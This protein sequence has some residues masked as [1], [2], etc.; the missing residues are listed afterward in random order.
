LVEIACH[1][2]DPEVDSTSLLYRKSNAEL[3]CDDLLQSSINCARG[4]ALEAIAAF[5]WEQPES[6]K[7]FEVTLEHSAKD[8]N[9]A[10]LFSVLHCSV[11]WY[12]IDKTF[13]KTLFDKL[14]TR[15]LRVLGVRQAWDLMRL[16]YE[17]NP[18][19][20]AERLQ[21][22]VQSPIDDL[23]N[24]AAQMVAKLVIMGYW[25]FKNLASLSLTAQQR[26]AVCHQ[27]IIYYGFDE[28]HIYCE[29]IIR[30]LTD[31]N[32]ELPSIRLLFHH[33]YLQIP[34]DQEFLIELLGKRYGNTIV[35][36]VLHYL[37]ETKIDVKNYGEILFAA[38][39]SLLSYREH[40]LKYYVN[41]LIFCVA[42]LFHAGK[43]DADVLTKCLDIWD[44]VYHV[45]P[46]SV[47]PM[48]DLLELK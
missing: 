17:S 40:S 21:S 20:Y 24:Y 39:K 42:Q 16:F 27:A 41:D 18:R 13:S 8:E 3:S 35:G 5:L 44:A 9:P 4:C 15:D 32:I 19:F 47:Q 12:N 25:P 46:Q 6:A 1:H 34:R 38:C 33:D 36:D 43:D 23:K 10:V 29:Q 48:A 2:R 22:A 31:D 7:Q 45:Y 26:D 11:P 30:W 37:K 14:L 28:G